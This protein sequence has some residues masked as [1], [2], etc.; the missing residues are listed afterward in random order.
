MPDEF[1]FRYNT[2]WVTQRGMAAV[3]GSSKQNISYHLSN[4]L[5]D[6]LN[7]SSVVKEI[8]TTAADGQ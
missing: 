2:V 1:V 7:E 8:L 3:L 6:E 5:N 4:I